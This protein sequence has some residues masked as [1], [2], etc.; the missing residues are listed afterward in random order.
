MSKSVTGNSTD[1]EIDWTMTDYFEDI[2]T[3]FANWI[4]E[5]ESI[6]DYLK[7]ANG[8]EGD[9]YAIS[10]IRNA[11]SNLKTLAEDVNKLPT[12]LTLFS[13]GS[14]CASQFL[15][16]QVNGLKANQVTFDKFY[17]YSEENSLPRATANFFKKVWIVFNDVVILKVVW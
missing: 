12:R 10:D 1:K 15:V 5:L 14:S 3:T 16:G 4:S 8:Y 6:L 17:V 13:E 7:Y 11:L 2:E 9:S